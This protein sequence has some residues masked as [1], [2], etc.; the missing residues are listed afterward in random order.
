MVT[1]HMC[2]EAKLSPFAELC[3]GDLVEGPEVHV[4]DLR[5]VGG[6][7]MV[8]SKRTRSGPKSKSF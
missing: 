1:G 5:H 3:R 4:E 7:D 2:L 8:Q 6:V